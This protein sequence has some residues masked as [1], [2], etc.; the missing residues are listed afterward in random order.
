MAYQIYITDALVCSS[1]AN[2]TSDKSY[3]LFTREAGMLWASARSVRVEKSKQRYALQE[4]S[5]ARVSLVR[6]KGGWKVTG[7]EPITNLYFAT[8]TRE[9]RAVIRNI[10]RTLHRFVQGETPIPTMYDD[11]VGALSEQSTLTQQLEV[12]L[13]L[14]IL[15]TLGYI[16][17]SLSNRALIE[18]PS[19]LGILS[20]MTESHEESGRESIAEAFTVSHL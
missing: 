18:A 20:T 3:L 1:R 7:A 8:T 16:A 2:N 14:R 15:S 11:V 9:E 5:L 10:V 17:P 19:A 6:G 4:F 13:T 12:L